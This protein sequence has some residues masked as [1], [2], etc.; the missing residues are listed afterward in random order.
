MSYFRAAE[1]AF[2]LQ[3]KRVCGVGGGDK[4]TLIADWAPGNWTSPVVI[5]C[6][7][8]GFNVKGEVGSFIKMW[9]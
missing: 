3:M 8:T 2:V 4:E 6:G 7:G 1:E 5:G 9:V